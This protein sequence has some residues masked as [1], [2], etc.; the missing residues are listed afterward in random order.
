MLE[1]FIWTSVRRGLFLSK[2][3]LLQ[4]LLLRFVC[5]ASVALADVPI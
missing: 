2:G 5:S 3:A 4:K 1:M